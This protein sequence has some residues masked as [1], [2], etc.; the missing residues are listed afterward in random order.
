VE[1]CS[2]LVTAGDAQLD[3]DRVRMVFDCRA[4]DAQA[5]RDLLVREA[6]RDERR[7][8]PLA[9][10]ETVAVRLA[11]SA[12]ARAVTRRTRAAARCDGH[13]SSPVA[14]ASTAATRSGSDC[15]AV[16][17]PAAP[18]SR[19]RT[20]ASSSVGTPSATIFAA[21]STSANECSSSAGEPW[22][23]SRRRRMARTSQ[24]SW[25]RH[26]AR[27]LQARGRRA[28]RGRPRSARGARRTSVTR[29]TP[30]RS[31]RP[32]PEFRRSEVSP[33]LTCVPS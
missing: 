8:L 32:P 11:S 17:N 9:R 6:V 12:A 30:M 26:R 24:R 1:P 10:R 14:A 29:S 19:I 21:R 28:R 2:D 31:R 15:S 25:R 20:I 27:S 13:F 22:R 23:C 7:D 33:S 18:A 4:L 5:P 16:T 3:Q